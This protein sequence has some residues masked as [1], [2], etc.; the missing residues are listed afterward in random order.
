MILPDPIKNS[1]KTMSEFTRYAIY[2]APPAQSD[3]ADFARQWLGY[4][5]E[6]GQA[7]DRLAVAGLS[8]DE[9]VRQT[10]SPS[11]YGFHG[12]LKPPFALADGTNLGQ[13]RDDVA[14]LAASL[15]P[16]KCGPL[17]LHR[18]GRFLA[19]VPTAPLDGLEKLAATLVTELDGYR[20]PEDEK[21]LARRR[22]AGLSARQDALLLEWG[23]PYVLDEF[24]FHLT[25]SEKLPE[26]DIERFVNALSPHV[27]PFTKAP[28]EIDEICLFGDPGEGRPF[29]V[30]E[31]FRLG[32]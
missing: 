7:V 14:R 25:L 19:L 8:D 10:G 32:G 5:P 27:A 23:Y 17:T 28:F 9:I 30:I 18:L 31:R 2:Y 16:V 21:G 4:D 12:T 15:A 20:A 29:R 11:R 24:R 26:W 6:T 1:G 22:A 3:L 13:L